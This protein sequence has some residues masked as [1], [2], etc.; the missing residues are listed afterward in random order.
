MLTIED[1]SPGNVHRMRRARLD[2]DLTQRGLAERAG[3]SLG[4]LR[5]FERTGQI[6][7]G[8]L[9]QIA[10]VLRAVPGVD[11]LFAPAEVR[12]LDEIIEG[13]RRQRGRRS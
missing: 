11:G 5:R 10:F 2:R 12:S 4:S 7:L 13:P 8:S 6:S 1:R 9:V 3:V